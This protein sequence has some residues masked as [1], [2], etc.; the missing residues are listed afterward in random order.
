MIDLNVKEI[1]IGCLIVI[2]LLVFC[3]LFI[4]Y[5]FIVLDEL[6]VKLILFLVG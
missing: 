4:I 1:R 5:Y 6:I 3:I 2:S